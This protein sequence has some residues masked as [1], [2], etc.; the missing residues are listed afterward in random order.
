MR[1]RWALEEVGQRNDV[2]LLSLRAMAGVIAAISHAYR[3]S[4][5]KCRISSVRT[6]LISSV[7]DHLAGCFARS[8]R[9][10][11]WLPMPIHSLIAKGAA[12]PWQGL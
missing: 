2:R 9:A 1:V 4:R 6:H 7:E 8:T 12:R 3:S 11:E 10:P 5:P